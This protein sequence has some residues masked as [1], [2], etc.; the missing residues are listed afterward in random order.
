HIDFVATRGGTY[1]LHA[2]ADGAGTGSYTLRSGFFDTIPDSLADTS[3][4][5][6]SLTAGLSRVGRVESA[7]DVDVFGITLRAGQ[8]YSFD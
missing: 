1:H 4:P 5:A 2:M 8:G 3:A 6:A 7:G